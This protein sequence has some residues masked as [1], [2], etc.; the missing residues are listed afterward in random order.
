MRDSRQN[1]VIVGG[2]RIPFV[3]S[4]GSYSRISNNEMLSFVLQH[5]V[6]KY[7]LQGKTIGDFSA[8]AVM[9]YPSDFNLSREVIQNSGLS[10]YTPG[11]NTQRAC[12]TSLETVV[13]MAAKISLGLLDTAIAGGTDTNSDIP[14][15]GRKELGWKLLDLRSARTTG[16]KLKALSA[17]S[18]KDLKPVLPAVLEPRTKLSMGQH[19][20]KMVQEWGIT[21]EAQDQLALASHKNGAKAYDEGFFDDLVIEFKGVK[22]DGTLRGDTSIEKLAKL[23]PAF[24]FTGKG[25]LTAGNSSPL[26]DGASA[27]FMA[28][29]AFAKTNGLPMLARVVDAQVAAVDY[30]NGDGLLMGPTIAVGNL[31]KRNNLKFQDFDYYEIH[32]AFAGQVLCNLAGW[33][34][35]AYCKKWL[36]L[37]SPLGAIDRSKMNVKGGS[38]AMGHPFAATGGR[39][40]ATLAKLLA[41]DHKRSQAANGRPSRGLISICT[42]GGM[43]IAAILE[44]V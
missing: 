36:D 16:E 35:A 24:D 37:A 2:L 17:F 8:G 26:S 25:T 11:Y 3:K 32:E 29:E 19:T 1:A 12:G 42:A 9:M 14:I 39:I 13:Q 41:Q 38:V 6:N 44:S 21:R 40:V 18:L 5:L 31:I 33:E 10:A 30:V 28:S 23:K 34:S 15:T 27:V 22:R 7:N 20:E 43:G 4:F